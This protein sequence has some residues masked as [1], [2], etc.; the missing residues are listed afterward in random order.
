MNLIDELLETTEGALGII[1]EITI[2]LHIVNVRP[3]GVKRNFGRIITLQ[4]L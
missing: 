1:G 2:I 4:Y 3:D